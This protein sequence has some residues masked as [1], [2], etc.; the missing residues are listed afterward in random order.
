MKNF[1]KYLFQATVFPFLFVVILGSIIFY[2]LETVLR[3]LGNFVDESYVD[4][5][6]VALLIGIYYLYI[7]FKK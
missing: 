3:F 6:G 1:F 5:L 4:L 2:P 7:K